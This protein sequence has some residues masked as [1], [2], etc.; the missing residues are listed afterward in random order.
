MHN[1]HKNSSGFLEQMLLYL[2]IEYIVKGSSYIHREGK[3]YFLNV[4]GTIVLKF[5]INIIFYLINS[6]LDS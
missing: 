3:D 1:S 4:A 5:E 6:G 2:K